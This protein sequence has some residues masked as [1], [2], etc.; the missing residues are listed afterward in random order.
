MQGEE[1]EGGEGSGN[2]SINE[3]NEEGKSTNT[4]ER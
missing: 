3:E 1:S 2:K 4:K